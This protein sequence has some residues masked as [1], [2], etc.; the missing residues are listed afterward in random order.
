MDKVIS[1]RQP[2][3]Q[4]CVQGDKQFETRSWGC[5]YRGELYIHASQNF[6]F[7]DLELCQADEDFKACIPDPTKLKTGCILGKVKLVSIQPVETVT[8]SAR[9]RKFGDYRS[10]LGRLAWKLEKPEMISPIQVKGKLS[11][12]ETKI[13]KCSDI[14]DFEIFHGTKTEI[15]EGM[16]EGFTDDGRYKIRSFHGH[17]YEVDHCNIKGLVPDTIKI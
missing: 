10:G 2:W 17:A 11:V 16:I 5:T 13:Y 9:E 1:L 6:H 3:A 7:S 15:I 8:I 14:V 4:L 12:W